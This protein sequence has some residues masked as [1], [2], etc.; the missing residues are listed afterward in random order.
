M[1]RSRSSALRRFH[2]KCF[3]KLSTEFRTFLKSLLADVWI[4]KRVS[5]V[6]VWASLW[7]QRL[8]DWA[9]MRHPHMGLFSHAFS[10]LSSESG[11]L[12]KT[13]LAGVGILQRVPH[14]D[15]RASPRRRSL[16]D[17]AFL[18]LPH[19]GL[20]SPVARPR[21]QGQQKLREALAGSSS[22][23]LGLS[24]AQTPFSSR[25]LQNGASGG[26]TCRSSYTTGKV[27]RPA[28]GHCGGQA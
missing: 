22:G 6:L 24:I 1:T 23:T 12:L 3:P 20:F 17:W 25:G 19:K 2:V 15:V 18:Q 14:V 9:F 16:S 4:L 7:R 27:S 11:T 8:W 28:R 5:H 21:G 13:L 10:E 26:G